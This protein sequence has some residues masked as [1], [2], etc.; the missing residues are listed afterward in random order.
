[1][2][3]NSV[4]NMLIVNL[5]DLEMWFLCKSNVFKNE[6]LYVSHKDFYYTVKLKQ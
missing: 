2:K 4:V 1:M 5:K 3:T 6:S